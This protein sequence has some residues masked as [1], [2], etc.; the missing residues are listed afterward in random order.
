MYTVLFIEAVYVP[1]SGIN[2]V[3]VS[4]NILMQKLMKKGIILF[5][6]LDALLFL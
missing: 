2:I 5:K 1:N 3:H 4:H 6:S